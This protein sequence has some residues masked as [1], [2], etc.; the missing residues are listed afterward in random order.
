M[1]SAIASLGWPYEP[2]C[3]YVW[4]RNGERVIDLSRTELRE[5]DRPAH[6]RQARRRRAPIPSL[7]AVESR[8]RAIRVVAG[9]MRNVLHCSA[10]YG[11]PAVVLAAHS[12]ELPQR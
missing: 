12:P 5:Q 2:V 6:N 7:T 11:V 4:Q 3:A 1:K 9:A 10:P 8:P